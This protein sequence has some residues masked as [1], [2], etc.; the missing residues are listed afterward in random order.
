MNDAFYI[1]VGTELL[2]FRV[3]LYSPVFSQKLMRLGF[4]LKGELTACDEL[5]SI[6][7]ALNFA[8]KRADLIIISGGLGPTFD[9][10][11]REAVSKF[12]NIN[13]IYS[14]EVERFLLDKNCDISKPNIKNQCYVIESAKLIK[15]DNGT[16]FGEVISTG[17]KCFVILP[18]PKNEWESMWPDVKNIVLK[19]FQ[20][21]EIYNRVIRFADIS[22][23]SLENIL[24]PIMQKSNEL[25]Y[26][27]LAGPNSCDFSIT[28][29]NKRLVDSVV[30]EIKGLT[31]EYIYGYDDDTIEGVVGKMLSEKGRN[32]SIAESCTGGLVSSMITDV[33]GSS[34]YYIGGINAYSNEIKERILNVKKETLEK[35][36][37]VSEQT[38]KEMSEN[39]RT[40]FKTDYSVSITGI[41]GPD[42]GSIE[43][44]VGLVFFGMSDKDKTIVEKRTFIKKDRLSIK[45]AASNTALYFLYKMIK[46]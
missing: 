32:L 21:P 26:T 22:E 45:K 3:N 2:N 6:I 29:N 42:G 7:D 37:A 44:P 33:S 40:I 10:L 36:G 12:L 18:G 31:N 30:D 14:K 11:T 35:Y 23:V 9:D 13:I 20:L 4:N 41:A 1:A 15:N 43:K 28:H 46:S 27:V 17:K 39:V 16:A 8:S 24:R 25:R 38:A 34:R 5:N 19:E